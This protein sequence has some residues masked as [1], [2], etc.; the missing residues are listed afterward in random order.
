MIAFR[1]AHWSILAIAWLFL[2][3]RLWR[4]GQCRLASDAERKVCKSTYQREGTIG[5][6]AHSWRS[7]PWLPAPFKSESVFVR[8]SVGVLSHLHKTPY[9]TSPDPTG[10]LT[11][12]RLF[13]GQRRDGI[14]LSLGKCPGGPLALFSR[15]SLRVSGTLREA[16]PRLVPGSFVFTEI[17]NRYA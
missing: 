11:F 17:D 8:V 10:L 5:L 15:F 3:V 9:Q 4:D 2:A 12:A 13:L 7:S 1:P 6:E 16:H 14:A